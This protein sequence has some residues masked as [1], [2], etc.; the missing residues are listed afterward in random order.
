MPSLL[1]NPPPSWRP[2]EFIIGF[3]KKKAISRHFC[4]RR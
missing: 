2:N 3:F 1:L 4:V